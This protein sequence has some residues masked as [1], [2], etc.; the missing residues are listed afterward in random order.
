MEEKRNVILFI[1]YQK[2]RSG[3]KFSYQKASHILCYEPVVSFPEAC[4]RTVGW[5]VGWLVDFCRVSRERA[6][7]FK[8]SA[9][10][11]FIK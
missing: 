4:K 1:G 5:L 2:Q 6:D 8:N 10:I 3:K 9:N 11:I 7:R